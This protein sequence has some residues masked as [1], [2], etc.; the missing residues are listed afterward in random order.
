MTCCGAATE[1]C[2]P[3]ETPTCLPVRFMADWEAM[4]TTTG[5]WS[6]GGCGALA[7]IRFRRRLGDLQASQYTSMSH[8]EG[9]E[10][11]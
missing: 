5:G 3:A 2:R 1:G 6:M 11:G 4:G 10:G 8:D 9:K 7:D